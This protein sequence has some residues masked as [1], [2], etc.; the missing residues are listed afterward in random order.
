[1]IPRDSHV[2]DPVEVRRLTGQNLAV[3]QAF[4]R[5]A[6]PRHVRIVTDYRRAL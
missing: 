1:M 2:T 5:K 4:G 6:L 3:L